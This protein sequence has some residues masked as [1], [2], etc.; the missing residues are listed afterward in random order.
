MYLTY[1]GLL[2]IG[3]SAEVRTVIPEPPWPSV[4]LAKTMCPEISHPWASALLVVKSGMANPAVLRATKVLTLF[5]A[6]STPALD[7][8]IV[9][10]RG[11]SPAYPHRRLRF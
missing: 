2:G 6:M 9:A 11:V 5:L 1:K 4:V 7:W 3:S 8:R 10:P